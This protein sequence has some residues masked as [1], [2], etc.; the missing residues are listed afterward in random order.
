MRDAPEPP[1]QVHEQGAKPQAPASTR[2]P[3][4]IVAVVVAA[5]AGL[6]IWY[7]L[8]G[9]PVL[10]QGEVDATR[11]DVAA[12]HDVRRQWCGFAASASGGC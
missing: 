6:S 5:V 3:S 10:V 12:V 7:L 11:F 4:T 2:V 8:R 9:E 1:K